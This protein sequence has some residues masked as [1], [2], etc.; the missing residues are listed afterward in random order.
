MN[1]Q[2]EESRRL[3]LDQVYEQLRTMTL[4]AAGFDPGV[5]S[6]REKLEADAAAIRADL[7]IADA[8]PAAHPG[9]NTRTGWVILVVTV[10]LVI[11]LTSFTV[12]INWP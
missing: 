11:L 6:E 2:D 12:A 8:R 5:H 1:D 7:G 3:R 4:G 9:R 10:V